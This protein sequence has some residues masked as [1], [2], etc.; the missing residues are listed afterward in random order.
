[1]F[2]APTAPAPT[3]TAPVLPPTT[4]PPAP[5][6]PPTRRASRVPLV[7]LV[8][9]V[10][11]VALGV[12]GY[13]AYGAWQ[14]ATNPQGVVEA[15]MAASAKITSAHMAFTA[16]A[17]I[18]PAALP[19]GR[20]AAAPI[21]FNLVME[22]SYVADPANPQVDGTFS[23]TMPAGTLGPLPVS[24]TISVR[25]KTADAVFVRVDQLP[26]L[27]FFDLSSLAGQWVKVDLS[28]LQ[29]RYGI[30]LQ[31]NALTPQRPQ[32][33]QLR[34]LYHDYPFLAVSRL[35]PETVDAVLTDHLRFRLDPKRMKEF[36]VAASSELGD[37][38][39]TDDELEQYDEFVANN[40]PVVEGELWIGRED[41]FL[42]Q[43]TADAAVDAKQQGKLAV[44]LRETITA[45]NQSVAI[46]EP[47][48][49]I[50]LEEAMRRLQVPSAASF[51][52]SI[53][54]DNAGEVTQQYYA[55]D[56]SVEVDG[57]PDSDNDGLSN[58]REQLLGADYTQADSDGDGYPDGE[59]VARGY[60]PAGSGALTSQQQEIL[61]RFR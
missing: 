49:A 5:L 29:E 43:L 46:E 34:R 41:H 18:T 40:G 6:T 28:E 26:P 58:F 9:L 16:D 3:P 27:P 61:S 50:S 36:I 22:A 38:A 13:F 31:P 54:V 4:P 59:E 24:P 56:G 60:N 47:A 55:P 53:A 57:S 2:Q 17:T 1:M 10:I 23:L 44:R 8:V 32:E 42:R 52:R 51:D 7:V 11:L 48:D 37:R 21:T 33:E 12:G 19:S 14:Q 15:A 39:P 25:K 30:S 35:S 20:A 45:I